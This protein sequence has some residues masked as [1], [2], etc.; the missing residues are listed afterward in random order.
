VSSSQTAGTTI[1]RGPGA[2]PEVNLA[3]G[4]EV[5]PAGQSTTESTAPTVLA[6]A[7]GSLL[8][9]AM[10]SGGGWGT[11]LLTG[12]SLLGAAAAGLYA[13]QKR[14]QAKDKTNG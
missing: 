12:G 2:G 4:P 5:A 6:K 7:G 13:Y 14:K 1:T 3:V 11:G 9:A 8:R 10:S